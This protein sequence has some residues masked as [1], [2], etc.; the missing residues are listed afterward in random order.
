V[1]VLELP[2]AG[3]NNSLSICINNNPVNLFDILKGN[4]DKDGSWSPQ[5]SNGNG[6]FYPSIDNSGVYTY[7]VD[8]GICGIDTA[9]ITVTKKTI[10]E[11]PSYFIKTN[12]FSDKNSLEIIINTGLEYE[13]SLDGNYY[14]KENV[15]NNLSGG[16]YTIFAR[17]VKGCGFLEEK[18]SLLNYPNFFTPNGDGYNDIWQLN[19]STNKKYSIT[20]FNRFGKLLKELTQNNPFWDGTYNNIPQ[21]SDDYWFQIKFIDGKTQ[22]GHFSLKR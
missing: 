3:E 19:G 14:Q 7:T 13:Y 21:P 22:R 10:S 15:F 4:P 6:L 8:H 16:D 11:I 2:N 20:I 9:E 17:E 18:V 1:N 5:L 12:D